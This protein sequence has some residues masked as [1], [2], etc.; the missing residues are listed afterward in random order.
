MEYDLPEASETVQCVPY[1][2]KGVMTV[3]EAIVGTPP[4]PLLRQ[5]QWG[6]QNGTSAVAGLGA[7]WLMRVVITIHE[8]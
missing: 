5:P 3:A 6:I 4:I 8:A 2:S 7:K 1:A